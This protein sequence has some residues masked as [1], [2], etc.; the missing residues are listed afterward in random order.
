MAAPKEK[1]DF[2][3]L[4]RLAGSEWKMLAI[5][6]VFLA[7]SSATLLIFPQVIKT[8]IDEAL[9]SKDAKTINQVA[10]MALG[11]FAV[12]SFAGAMRYYFFHHHR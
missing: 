6:T 10:L 12:Q 3:K 9:I 7:I 1:I 8:I 5:G 2:R 11:L 4:Y